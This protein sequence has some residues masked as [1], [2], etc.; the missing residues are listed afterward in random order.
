ML[1]V[2]SEGTELKT[3]AMHHKNYHPSVNLIVVGVYSSLLVGYM[4]Y[5]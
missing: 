3:I 2:R 5:S 4:I 1:T